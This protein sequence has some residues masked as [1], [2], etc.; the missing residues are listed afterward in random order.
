MA[1]PKTELIKF[2]YGPSLYIA[3]IGIPKELYDHFGIHQPDFRQAGI[4]KYS[5][6]R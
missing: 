2:G 5:D 3:D 6:L 4:V 1:A